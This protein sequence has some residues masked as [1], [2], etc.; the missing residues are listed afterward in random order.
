MSESLPNSGVATVAQ[1]DRPSP[2]GQVLG[3]AK[4]APNRR[5]GRRHDGLFER[6]KKHRQHDADDDR[7]C[8]RVANT[9]DGSDT[10]IAVLGSGSNR[11]WAIAHRYRHWARIA[12]IELVVTTYALVT[13]LAAVIDARRPGPSANRAGVIGMQLE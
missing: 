1:I 6:G 11:S 3:I 13:H 5:Q 10:S 4:H 8:G 2:P 12:G 9:F 7:E